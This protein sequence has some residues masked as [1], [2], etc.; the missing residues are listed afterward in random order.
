MR[1]ISTPLRDSHEIGNRIFERLRA[2]D[3][4]V[5]RARTH[6]LSNR[7]GASGAHRRLGSA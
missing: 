3:D 2:Y 5:A 4:A 6:A 7:A 1:S